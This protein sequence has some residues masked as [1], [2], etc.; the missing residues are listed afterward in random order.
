[1]A[2]RKKIEDD[3][4]NLLF[5]EFVRAVDYFQ[6]KCFLIENVIGM[7]S[8]SISS[9]GKERKVVD[10]IH[11]YFQSL[12]YEIT[13]KELIAESKSLHINEGIRIISSLTTPIH[14]N[15]LYKAC[16]PKLK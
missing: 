5:K 13:F 3:N 9:S 12:G 7:K 2:N 15:A 1:M 8:E 11:D 4:R 10:T 14:C 6:P 16:R